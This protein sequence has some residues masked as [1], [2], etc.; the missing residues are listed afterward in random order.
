MPS[1]STSVEDSSS[2]LSVREPSTMRGEGSSRRSRTS[3]NSASPFGTSSS[4]GSSWVEAR[5]VGSV[6]TRSLRLLVLGGTRFVGRALVETALERGHELTL[7]NRGVTNPDLFPNVAKIHGDRTHD[8]SSL[9]GQEWDAVVD[10]AAYSPRV[11]RLS[12][13]AL[14]ASVERYAFVSRVSV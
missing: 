6:S 13:D 10:V 3:A 9:A 11:A 5:S 12:V 2:R 7:F 8:L 4:C 1:A 14:R